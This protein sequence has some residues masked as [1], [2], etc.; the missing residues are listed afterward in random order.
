[1]ASPRFNVRNGRDVSRE[2]LLS[3][4]ISAALKTLNA[5]DELLYEAT[6]VAMTGMGLPTV[7]SLNGV[8]PRYSTADLRVLEYSLAFVQSKLR[9]AGASM[10]GAVVT[11]GTYNAKRGEIVLVDGT[12]SVV[13]PKANALTNEGHQVQVKLVAP[14]TGPVTVADA[15]GANI[16]GAASFGPIVVPGTNI[17]F[18]HITGPATTARRGGVDIDLSALG[19]ADE[20]T[21]NGTTY[22]EGIDFSDAATLEAAINGTE[23]ELVAEANG[24]IVTVQAVV[25]GRSNIQLLADFGAVTKVDAG[26]V[27][28]LTR[29]GGGALSPAAQMNVEG[30]DLAAI[31][32]FLRGGAKIDIS[33]S[34]VGD[35]V[36]V[37]AETY[38]HVAAAP[39]A[40]E[41]T[42]IDELVSE[43][44]ADFADLEAEARGTILVLQARVVG[45]DDFALDTL[46][47]GPIS[48]TI[49]G[50]AWTR[51]D[52][53]ALS[54]AAQLNT[55]GS[56]RGGY[57]VVV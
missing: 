43:I 8:Q 24:D 12:I 17:I 55:V 33:Q 46:V 11:S 30:S 31:D 57:Y 41:Y 37:G 56:E 1:M 39:A 20:V 52:G 47:G 14:S 32:K 45:Q 38:T 22:V 48:T 26:G 51:V 27:I 16:D 18:K 6:L 21:I 40:N 4:E 7:Y 42:N 25:A 49:T 36:V 44:N 53:N 23:T 54:P 50:A 3:E 13:L 5:L 2:T 19:A 29:V 35:T 9:G 15:G 28:S 10:S 34:Q